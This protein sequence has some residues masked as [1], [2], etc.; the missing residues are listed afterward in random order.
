MLWVK[1]GGMLADKPQKVKYQLRLA[2]EFT[3]GGANWQANPL[4]EARHLL[5]LLE[6]ERDSCRFQANSEGRALYGVKAP[7]EY[8]N[9]GNPGQLWKSGQTR[10]GG[11]LQ[12]AQA[13]LGRSE[14][15]TTLE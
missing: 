3:Y 5:Y 6:I 9:C 14:L 13:Q 10:A 12:D 7:Y 2:N 8:Q 4:L 1:S 15:S 11:S